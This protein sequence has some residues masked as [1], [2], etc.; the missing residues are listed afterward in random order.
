[1][2]RD[3]PEGAGTHAGEL[4]TARLRSLV[5]THRRLFI[6]VIVTVVGGAGAVVA[7]TRTADHTS[8]APDLGSARGITFEGFA[9][10][11]PVEVD[12]FRGKPLVLNYWASWCTFCIVEMPEFQDVYERVGDR[13]EF[14]GI[15]VRDDIDDART[16]ARQTG[17]RYP[18]AS[19]PDGT[20]F[21]RL[22]GFSM[23]TTWFIDTD[24]TIVERFSGPLTGEQL[25]DRIEEHFGG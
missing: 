1:M 21:R 9:T 16:L 22:R 4:L 14:L 23:P 19:D 24:G 5:H 20:R 13:I 7:S 18:L 25:T 10:T 12:S 2:G 6:L 8:P 3:L 17:V 15:N 11:P